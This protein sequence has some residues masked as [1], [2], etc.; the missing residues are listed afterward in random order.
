VGAFLSVLYSPHVIRRMG[1]RHSVGFSMALLAA[2]LIALPFS[3]WL[4]LAVAIYAMMGS[5]RGVGGIAISSTMM[6]IVPKHF[7]GR[8]QNTFYFAGTVL[9]IAFGYLVGVAA[10]KLALSVGFF[11][12]GTMYAIAALTAMWPVAPPEQ[13]LEPEPVAAEGSLPLDF[14][15]GRAHGEC[16]PANPEHDSE[17]T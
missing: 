6:E 16:V 17:R 10:H 1:S 8:V 2:G 7:M 12:V 15:A 4:G 11:V 13:Y 14:G 5:A 9:Q 3:H